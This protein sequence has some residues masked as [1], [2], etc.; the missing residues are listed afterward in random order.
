MDGGGN[1]DGKIA[2]R[3][4]RAVDGC[5]DMFPGDR[6]P[7][8]RSH[9]VFEKGTQGG[10]APVQAVGLRT[11][12]QDVGAD[13]SIAKVFL[14]D[15]ADQFVVDDQNIGQSPD[16]QKTFPVRTPLYIPNRRR[17]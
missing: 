17:L 13:R 5:L 8:L 14:A 7:E 9:R 6:H 15:Q 10:V 11:L 2:H 16:G 12:Q 1:R 4:P 3:G